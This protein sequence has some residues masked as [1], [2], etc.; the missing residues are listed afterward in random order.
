VLSHVD[1]EHLLRRTEFVARPWRVLE[2]AAKNSLAEAVDDVMATTAPAG[3][4]YTSATDW[5][6][7]IEFTYFWFDQMA[8]DSPR[9]LLEKM[10]MFWHGHFCTSMQ[11]IHVFEPLR[12]QID[13]FRGSGLG[14]LRNL[15]IAMSTQPAMLR[16]LDND[17]N[18]QSSPNQNFARELMELFL[19]GVG[20]YT[21]DDVEAGTAAWTGHST[22]NGTFSY[23]WHPEWHDASAKSYLGRTINGGT[24]PDPTRHG[25]QTIEVILGNG[26]V[27]V[28]PNAGRPTRE[29]AA[30]F[31]SRKLWRFFAGTEPSNTVLSAL[32]QT[33][34]ANDFALRPWIRA[35]LLRPEF[36]AAE[37]RQ[38]LVRSPVDL[39]VAYLSATGLR[40]STVLPI[41][42]M[43]GMGQKPL[44]PPDVSGWK[45]NAYFVNASAMAQRSLAAR[46]FMWSTMLGYWAGDGLLHLGAGTISRGEAEAL[47]PHPEQFVDLVLSKMMLTL[48]DA[49]REVL[50]AHARQ[51]PWYERHDLIALALLA[52]E[53]QLA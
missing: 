22:N 6:H 41:W 38:G 19:L 50:Y 17:Q 46:Y 30:E 8:F 24:Q 40:A 12:H 35:L 3:L 44:F 10:A 4:S 48:S 53:L 26:I 43:E 23:E 14:N 51:A 18:R 33:A 25:A 37:A 39:M 2:L 49:S 1:I 34:I 32:R 29:V 11:K 15:T 28:G 9:P 47:D 7:N 20:N 42:W 45:H 27:P 36:Y 5:D 21:E 52:P 13:L 16:Y 31:M